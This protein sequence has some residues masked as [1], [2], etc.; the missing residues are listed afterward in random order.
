MIKPLTRIFR[1]GLTGIAACLMLSSCGADKDNPGVEYAPQMYHS[2]AYE[3]LSQVVENDAWYTAFVG[4][5]YSTSPVTNNG[6][7]SKEEV[8]G[9]P[10]K[11]SKISNMLTPPKGTVKRQYYAHEALKD[12]LLI[13]YDAYGKDDLEAAALELKNPYPAEDEKVV[14]RGKELYLSYCSPCHGA[15]GKGDGKVGEK[16]GGVPDYSAG[17]YKTL[18]EGHI[19]HVITHGKGR[20]WAHKGLVSPED[21]WKIVRYVQQLQQGKP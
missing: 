4:D 19:F 20:M 16:Y 13:Y 2:V 18:S 7:F 3:P 15:T 1:V 9:D 8:L 6:Y 21:R 17:R 11:R 10:E 14:A 12:S 5:Y